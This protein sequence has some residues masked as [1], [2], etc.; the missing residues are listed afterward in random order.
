M[1]KQNVK[2]N[3]IALKWK[4]TS[5][6]SDR[7]AIVRLNVKCVIWHVCFECERSYS[8]S[9]SIDNCIC[10][11]TD[12]LKAK[13]LI[14]QHSKDDFSQSGTYQTAFLSIDIWFKNIFHWNSNNNYCLHIWEL[15]W[16]QQL[17]I[18]CKSLLAT[19]LKLLV[20]F[21]TA[22]NDIIYSSVLF[23]VCV[24]VCATKEIKIQ[25]ACVSL[26]YIVDALK[27]IQFTIVVVF[28]IHW[29]QIE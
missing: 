16:I 23:G 5:D 19:A 12:P 11:C 14:P 15:V 21:I 1:I 7:S 3:F 10:R 13:R 27:S 29:V 6:S 20:W 22:F 25:I 17:K 18:L 9:N 8:N 28:R 26:V 2:F 24:C 4:A